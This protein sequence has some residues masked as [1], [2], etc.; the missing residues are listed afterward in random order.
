MHRFKNILSVA[1]VGIAAVAQAYDFSYT[2][3]QTGLKLCFDIDRSDDSAI[4]TAA[5]IDSP[6]RIKP[7]TVEIPD[8]VNHNGKIY[9]VTAIGNRAFANNDKLTGVILPDNLA[10]LGDGVFE[11]CNNLERVEFTGPQIAIPQ[12]TFHKC[13]NIS[14][15]KFGGDWNTADYSPFKYSHNIEEVK[16]PVNIQFVKG[17]ELLESL[18]RIEVDSNNMFFSSPNACLYSKN[19]KTL[20]NVP[21]AVGGDDN[22]F[23]ISEGTE[24]IEPGAFKNCFN[25]TRLE[26]PESVMQININE[27]I[28]LEKLNQVLFYSKKPIINAFL[29]DPDKKKKGEGVMLLI[30]QP[31]CENL[32]F[33]TSGSDDAYKKVLPAADAKGFYDGAGET[34]NTSNKIFISK[35]NLGKKK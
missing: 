27:L 18:E 24:I 10:E 16:I 7:G 9:D 22:I 1:L 6:S 30:I 17:I 20:K 32:E 12:L 8:A 19:G 14:D 2:D 29:Y 33:Y 4:L 15:V 26:I 13:G 28:N 25:I 3:P 34:I 35:D 11:N 5:A 21:A 23:K 31:Q